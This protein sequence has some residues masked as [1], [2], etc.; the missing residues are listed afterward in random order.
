ML[1]DVR[2]MVQGYP[3]R[4]N[5]ENEGVILQPPLEC[6]ESDEADGRGRSRGRK[7]KGPIAR[8]GEAFGI[9]MNDDDDD[10][11]KTVDDANWKE[12]KPGE[13]ME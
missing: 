10:D 11:D 8:L 1:N 5:I 12:L 6:Q 4:H 13:R 2:G 9:D 3:N 7:D